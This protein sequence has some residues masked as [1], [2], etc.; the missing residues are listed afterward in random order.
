[1]QSGIN[2]YK[3]NISKY[4]A[5]LKYVNFQKKSNENFNRVE[6]YNLL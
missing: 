1:M 6:R 4:D 3:K 2:F 5:I